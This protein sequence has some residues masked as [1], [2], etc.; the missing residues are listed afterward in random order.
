MSGKRTKKEQEQHAASERRRYASLKRGLLRGIA[1]KLR[2]TWPRCTM[3]KPIKGPNGIQLLPCNARAKPRQPLE[4]EHV[5]F[6][7]F[8]QRR[9]NSVQRLERFA[10]ELVRWM[11]G[12]D[13][14]ALAIACRSCNAAKQPPRNK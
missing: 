2:L 13:S 11:G 7:R 6:T 12:D 8:R 4:I 5:H 3:L 9:L 10:A 14:R 1:L